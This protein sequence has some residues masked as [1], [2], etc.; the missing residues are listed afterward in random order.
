MTE[1]PQ[2][3]RP[4]E[5]DVTAFADKLDKWA[6]TLPLEERGLLQLLLA[7][8][9]AVGGTEIG[10]QGEVT[11]GTSPGE[12]A[13]A[14]LG[15]ILQGNVTALMQPEQRCKWSIWGSGNPP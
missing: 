14:M 4:S 10:L 9:E 2:E 5:A 11:I 1:Q 3:I 13:S 8:A 15:R 7:R 6:E 12:A